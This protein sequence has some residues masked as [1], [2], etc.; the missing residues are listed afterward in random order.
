MADLGQQSLCWD[1]ADEATL[2]G[3]SRNGGRGKAGAA[4]SFGKLSL[5]QVL[6]SVSEKSGNPGWFNCQEEV[7]NQR[8]KKKEKEEDELMAGLFSGE[9]CVIILSIICS[10]ICCFCF[11]FV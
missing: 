11:S 7:R 3:T 2:L 10:D 9:S 4:V 8:K 5:N 6:L 1:L